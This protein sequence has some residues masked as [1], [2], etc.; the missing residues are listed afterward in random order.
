MKQAELGTTVEEEHQRSDV[1]QLGEK[2]A[3]LVPAEMQR[4]EEENSKLKKLVADLS[5]DK[6]MLQDSAVKKA[7]KP[8]RKRIMIDVLVDRYR[9]VCDRPVPFSACRVRYIGISRSGK[10]RRHWS[11]ASRKLPTPACITDIDVCMSY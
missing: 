8:S 10:N 4:L 7:L 3:G 2:Y 9:R 5:L 1:L 6:L 11:C